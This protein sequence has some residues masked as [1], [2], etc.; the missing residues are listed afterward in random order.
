ML[1]GR[2]LNLID[3]SPLDVEIA[4]IALGLARNAR[5][6]G[7]THGPHAWS[8]AQHSDFVVDIV[9]RLDP[10]AK[11]AL[12]PREVNVD[13]LGL[14]HPRCPPLPALLSRHTLRSRLDRRP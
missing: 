6:N 5:W 1:S 9:R 8:V 4:D 11:P 12:L 3:P 7:Q 2:R 14:M 10:R 13:D